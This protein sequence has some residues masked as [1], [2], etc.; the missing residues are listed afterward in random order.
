MNTFKRK[1]LLLAVLASLAVACGPG[2]AS[3]GAT[4][5][6]PDQLA[7]LAKDDAA[8]TFCTTVR[9]GSAAVTS[10]YTRV[11]KGAQPRG[12][13]AVGADCSTV[14]DNTTAVSV[15]LQPPAGGAAPG[16]AK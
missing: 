4:G 7:A 6:T 10:T 5:M 8:T 3:L 16:L 1:A 9:Y 2:C 15:R 13:I 14:Q 12:G 11:D